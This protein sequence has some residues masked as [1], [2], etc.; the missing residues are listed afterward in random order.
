[1][2]PAHVLVVASTFPA[3][4]SDTVPR[5]VHDQVLALKRARPHVVFTVIA[6]HDRRSATVDEIDRGEFVEKRFHYLWPRRWESLAG[7]GIMPAIRK[8]RLQALAIPF[9]LWGEY[10]AIHRAVAR[11]RPHLIYA[12]WFTPQAVTAAMVSRR[13]GIPLVFTTHAS[14][15]AVWRAFG[16][17]GR[18]LV[19]S[20]VSVTCRYTAVSAASLDRMRQFFDEVEWQE[21]RD[22]GAIIPMGVDI[23]S[24]PSASIAEVR[25]PLN[26]LFVGRLAEKK[27]V[28]QLIDAFGRLCR[29]FPDARLTIAGDGP[30]RADLEAQVHRASLAESVQFVGYVTGDVKRQLYEAADVCVLPSIATQDGDTE[31]LPVSLLEALS[32]GKL[33]IASA[34]TNAGEVVTVEDAI[35]YDGAD[36]NALLDALAGV[37]E[38]DPARVDRMRSSAF[39]AARRFSWP[40]IAEQT[41]SFLLD[42]YI[43]SSTSGTF[44]P[45][46]RNH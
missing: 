42:P 20:V 41:A 32:Y 44:S 7:H 33:T 25:V 10:R 43:T 24:P 29:R 37:L 11:D 27:G 19:K 9:L 2:T 34:A 3:S 4:D 38:W 45:Q 31:G 46:D 35:V 13:T 23:V 28:K 18:S 15:V 17:V 39:D 21:V 36:P 12:H 22:K 1:M 40:E 26:F 30:L 6:P 5:F 14:D 8:N 16:R